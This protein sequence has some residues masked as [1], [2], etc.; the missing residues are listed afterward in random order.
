[1]PFALL[2]WKLA[3]RDSFDLRLLDPKVF[4]RDHFLELIARFEEF[5][6][7]PSLVSTLREFA[8]SRVHLSAGRRRHR[9]GCF[10]RD[11]YL[12][13]NQWCH[14]TNYWWKAGAPSARMIWEFLFGEAVPSR[15]AGYGTAEHVLAPRIE[16][17]TV[18]YELI[19]RNPLFRSTWS[20]NKPCCKRMAEAWG[21]LIYLGPSRGKR[22]RRLVVY[23]RDSRRSARIRFCP[24]CGWR[25][26]PS[27]F[28][29][30]STSVTNSV[31]L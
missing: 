29:E 23:A 7:R 28:S 11:G 21:S 5:G 2:R 13:L 16:T 4:N 20:D 18:W 14:G 27:L 9:D 12:N 26:R 17:W 19:S 31:S 24:F 8:D 30:Q 6:P 1:M 22:Q 10:E 15:I 3:G 25:I